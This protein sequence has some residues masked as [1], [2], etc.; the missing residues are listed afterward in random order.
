[1]RPEAGF[2]DFFLCPPRGP[3]IGPMAMAGVFVEEKDAAKLKSIGVKDSKLLTAKQR[4]ALFPKIIKMTKHYQI[5]IIP[6]KEIDDALFSDDLNLNWLEAHKAAEIINGFNVDK[7]IVD[8]P[9][10]NCR[11]Y[12]IYLKKLLKDKN[13]E[14]VCVHKA[15]VKYPEVGAASILAKVTRDAEMKKI[16]EKYG[17]IGPGYTSNP[18]TQKF[19]KENWE[20]YPEIFRHSWVSYKNHKE[21]KF[22]K[23]LEGFGEFLEKE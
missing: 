15:D 7:V 12:T 19:L 8:S 17:N 13:V 18:T 2:K 14:L 11:A 23:T 3:V 5:I 22:Q 1:M 4:E 21:N 6:A 10:N 20:K 16:Q 9:S